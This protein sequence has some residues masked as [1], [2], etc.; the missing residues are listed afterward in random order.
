M[1]LYKKQKLL[2]MLSP[3]AEPYH[4]ATEELTRKEKAMEKKMELRKEDLEAENHTVKQ[5]Y[6]DTDNKTSEVRYYSTSKPISNRI[7][8]NT[9]E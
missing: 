5:K 4:P 6:K 3:Y 2:G 7:A 9:T 8:S 1:S